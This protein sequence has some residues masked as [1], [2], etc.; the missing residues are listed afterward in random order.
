MLSPI[1]HSAIAGPRDLALALL[2]WLALQYWRLPA[3]LVVL[4]CALCGGLLGL[5]H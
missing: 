1:W 4:G 2:A 5:G 3:W